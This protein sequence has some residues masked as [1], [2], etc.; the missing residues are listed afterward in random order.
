MPHTVAH[1]P[2]R[3]LHRLPALALLLS[4]VLLLL[5]LVLVGE[6]SLATHATKLAATPTAV[7][8]SGAPGRR[9][10]PLQSPAI[11]TGA[12]QPSTTSPPP[13]VLLNPRTVHFGRQNTGT[14]SDVQ[15][16]YVVNLGPARLTIYTITIIGSDKRY[17]ATRDSCAGKI[18]GAYNGCTV[19]VRFTP[20]KAS[21]R[22][23]RLVITDNTAE[24]SQT[25]L[26]S[27]DG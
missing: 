15:T 11:G 3:W 17:F 19:S 13:I 18:I 25:V 27:G 14:T 9:P 26:M 16:V 10:K 4:L 23:S 20:I 21:T 22:R 1:R 5:L 7:R 24:G 6:H 2:R 8:T 12:R